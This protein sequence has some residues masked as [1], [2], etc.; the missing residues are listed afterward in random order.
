MRTLQLPL[1][2]A[3]EDT[4]IPD[5]VER[6]SFLSAHILHVDLLEEESVIEV[7]V[8]HTGDAEAISAAFLK[9]S[10]N[11]AQLRRFREKE[12]KSNI[13]LK[14]EPVHSKLSGD[15]QKRTF[16]DEIEMELAH[17]FDQL[18]LNMGASLGAK[19]RRYPSTMSKELMEKCKYH[20]NFPQNI[21]S[22]FE[23]PHD[24]QV[25]D[26]I[27]EKHHG[28][29]PEHFQ[30][31]GRFLQPCIC[32]HCYEEWEG[33]TYTDNQMMTAAGQCFRHEIS[34]KVDPLRKL[35]FS[36]REIVFIGDKEYINETRKT[37]L[38]HTWQCF[39]QLG[40]SGKV[41]TANDP[42]FF[43]DDMDKANYQLMANSKYE[44]VAV[45]E[46]KDVSI[47]SFNDCGE[48]LCERFQIKGEDDMPLY[49]GCA[50]F[51]I[52]RWVQVFLQTYGRNRKNW[53]D[54]MLHIKEGQ[55]AA[56]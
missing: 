20:T 41:T 29:L 28:F 46:K 33:K 39:H 53:P 49:S 35:E 50:A 17:Y 15:D 4:M 40:L 5:F 56:K 51:G 9:L 38:E 44:L 23:I 37:L 8:D 48:M 7:T 52:D 36:M 1:P 30:Q 42:F 55:Y 27:R 19:L 10:S 32:Y 13:H 14:S 6:V 47:A 45:T 25:I 18:F 54:E 43:Y 26:D 22:V 21:Y 34:W 16:Y 2:D 3:L 12:M 24:Y 11:V 31:A